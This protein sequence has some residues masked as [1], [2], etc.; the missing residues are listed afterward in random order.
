MMKRS[1]GGHIMAIDDLQFAINNKEEAFTDVKLLKNENIRIPLRFAIVRGFFMQLIFES[2][3]TQMHQAG[4]IEHYKRMYYDPKFLDLMEEEEE[5]NVLT[6]DH[7]S[8]GFHVFLLFVGVA[9][10]A[11][12]AE[13]SWF[14]WRK[15]RGS[16]KVV[17]FV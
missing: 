4:L 10:V 8:I 9:I 2:K 15:F 1:S 7:L 17:P 16:N 3:L 13:I 14:V 12:V 5:P 6:V 11:F